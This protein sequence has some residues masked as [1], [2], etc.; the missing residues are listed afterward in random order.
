MWKWGCYLGTGMEQSSPENS[1][2]GSHVHRM[3]IR[4]GN[5]VDVWEHV[6]ENTLRLKKTL[7]LCTGEVNILNPGS[8][9]DQDAVRK[10]TPISG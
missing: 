8:A 10:S 2:F 6:L 3:A 9:R 7:T 5:V 1:N 4:C